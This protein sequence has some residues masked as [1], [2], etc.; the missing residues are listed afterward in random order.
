MTERPSEAELVRYIEGEM[1]A[2]RAK[3]IEAM[4]SDHPSL[5]ADVDLLR[6]ALAIQDDLRDAMRDAPEAKVERRIENSLVETVTHVIEKAH[7]GEHL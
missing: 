3:Q 4:I 5:A 2:K 6:K 7:E 1:S